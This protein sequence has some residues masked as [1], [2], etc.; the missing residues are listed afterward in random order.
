MTPVIGIT[1]NLIIDEASH[2]TFERMTLAVLYADAVRA[3][4][5]IPVVLPPES[6]PPLNAPNIIDGLILSGGPDLAPSLYGDQSVHSATY[7]I[8]SQRD[9]FELDLLR[10]AISRDLPVLC[11]CRGIQ[12]LNVAF[13]GTLYQHLPDQL[14]SALLHRQHEA[15]IAF[16]HPG[17]VVDVVSGTLLEEVYGSGTTTVHVNSFH[18]QGIRDLAPNLTVNARSADGLIEAVS[19]P[20]ARFVLGVQWHPEMMFQAHADQRAPFEALAVAA[21]SRMRS[22]VP[23]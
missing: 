5:G 22:S 18:H 3:A 15:G 17:H 19:L 14:E 6:G 9:E 12:V 1:P 20:S 4:G 23:A 8:S 13:G 7:G 21:R 10:A 11:I 2:G 16:D